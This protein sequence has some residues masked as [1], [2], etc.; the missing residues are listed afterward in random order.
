MA[1]SYLQLILLFTVWAKIYYDSLKKLPA[2]PEIMAA[3]NLHLLAFE[4]HNY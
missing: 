1:R 3:L 2:S 4:P